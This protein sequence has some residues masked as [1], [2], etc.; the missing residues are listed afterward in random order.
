MIA[1][2]CISRHLNTYAVQ[3]SLACKSRIYLISCKVSRIATLESIIN[4][5]LP[6]CWPVVSKRWR[7]F[8][9]VL[10]IELLAIL[11]AEDPSK[12]SIPSMSTTG[13][14]LTALE[15]PHHSD[16]INHHQKGSNCWR[17]PTSFEKLLVHPTSFLTHKQGF[18][19]ITDLWFPVAARSHRA[20][21]PWFLDLEA[22]HT[23]RYRPDA[24]CAASAR[25]PRLR[26]EYLL[27]WQ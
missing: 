10:Y 20:S 12:H 26:Q 4:L 21:Q 11:K 6:N 1:L 19:T 14:G 22:L 5:L 25:Q 15:L 8:N 17:G 7:L 27:R 23:A 2:I 16:K 9:F 24:L 18:P 13:T 3:S